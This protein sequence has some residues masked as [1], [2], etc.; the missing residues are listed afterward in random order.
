MVVQFLSMFYIHC[1]YISGIERWALSLSTGMR[2]YKDLFK[3]LI[4]GLTRKEDQSLLDVL[5]FLYILHRETL[6]E[7]NKVNFYIKLI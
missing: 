1:I 5:I 6:F 2:A 7:E 4:D 3:Y